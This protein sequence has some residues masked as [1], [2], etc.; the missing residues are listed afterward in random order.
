M[1]VMGLLVATGAGSDAGYISLDWSDGWE[2]GYDSQ[3]IWYKTAS[4]NLLTTVGATTTSY[5]PI[6]ADDNYSYGFQIKGNVTGGGQYLSAIVYCGNYVDTQSE[7]ISSASSSDEDIGYADTQT[8][9]ITVTATGAEVGTYSDTCIEGISVSDSASAA[10][11]SPLSTTFRYYYGSFDGKIYA[12]LEDATSD[13]GED[14]DAIWESKDLDFGD[15][16][17]ELIDRNKTI[18]KVR[19]AYVDKSNAASLEVGVSTDGGTTWATRNKAVGTG[20]GTN[21]DTEFFFTSTGTYFRI[22]IRNKSGS[23][24]FQWARLTPLFADAGEN[25]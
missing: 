3:E 25:V 8:E 11:V 21:K 7:A 24:K 4:W 23:D 12:E 9:S 20:D 14:I 19:V 2:A 16:Y 1:A 10:A 6:S 5:G 18:F 15:M 22:R 13:D 17:P